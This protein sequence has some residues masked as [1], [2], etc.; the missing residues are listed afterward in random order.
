MALGDYVYDKSPPPPELVT[1]LNFDRWGVGDYRLLP[2]G[3]LP[4]INT[5]LNYYRALSGYRSAAGR[6]TQW[7]KIN[8]EAWNLASYYLK[9][10]MERARGNC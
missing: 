2:A 3:R 10:R 7:V 1:A 9:I 4:I 5:C 6:S 8:P